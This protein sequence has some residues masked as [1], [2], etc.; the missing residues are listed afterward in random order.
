M[1]DVLGKLIAVSPIGALLIIMTIVFLRYMTKR[2]TSWSNT[3]KEMSKNQVKS[4]DNCAK[5]VE[6]NTVVMSQVKQLLELRIKQ[7]N[8]E[9]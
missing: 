6:K 2:D 9:E 7:M 4:H 1:E 8:G 5:T 3:W